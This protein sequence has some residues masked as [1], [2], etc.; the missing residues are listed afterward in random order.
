MEYLGKMV[1]WPPKKV[2]CITNFAAEKPSQFSFIGVV[3][4][5]QILI[6]HPVAVCS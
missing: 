6:R 2:L 1:A 4:D 5:D 3:E